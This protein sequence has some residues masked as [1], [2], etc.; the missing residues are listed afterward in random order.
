MKLAITL[1]CALC[2]TM[3]TAFGQNEDVESREAVASSTLLPID[4][5]RADKLMGADIHGANGE[6]LAELSDVLIDDG[7]GS[8]RYA[9]LSCGGVLGIG[10]KVVAVP[11][12]SLRHTKTTDGGRRL[13]VDFDEQRIENLPDY[14]ATPEAKHDEAWE[15][16]VNT[17]FGE[18]MPMPRGKLARLS[19]VD[20]CDLNTPG[21][22]TI[23]DV[24]QV[25]FDLNNDRVAYIVVGAGG[26][27]GMGEDQI[28]FP[29]TSISTTLEAEGNVALSYPKEAKKLADAPRYDGDE[30]ERMASPTFVTKVYTFHACD[31]YWTQPI[32]AGTN[33]GGSQ[34]P[35][36]EEV[37]KHH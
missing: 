9:V 27:L 23:G 16:G 30:W 24:E 6:K 3:T 10:D 21:D 26:F 13:S 11:F 25:V 31:P 4:L 34:K 35:M 18:P 36:R 22:E 1:T 12:K 20:A 37:Q 5:E 7:T 8:A 33:R 17:P 28:A 14:D 32:E 29:W 15:R 19:K 2:A